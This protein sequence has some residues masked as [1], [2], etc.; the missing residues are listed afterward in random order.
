MLILILLNYKEKHMQNIANFDTS[1]LLPHT[2]GF[3]SLFDKLFDI[4]S[5]TIGYPP[6][7][8][9][10]LDELKYEISMALAGFN[11]DNIE[12]EISDGELTIKSKNLNKSEHKGD[13]IHKG[14][15]DRNFER[16]FTLSDEIQV[17]SAQMKDGMLY[18]SLERKIPEHKKP[19]V[20]SIK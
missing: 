6:Y 18:V 7:N 13:F 11:K 17:N 19:K 16:K 15:S 3:D 2:V 20:I 5:S 9:L 4:E 10:K 1:R 12:I 8:I 14:V